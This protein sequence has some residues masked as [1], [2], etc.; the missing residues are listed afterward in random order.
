[1]PNGSSAVVQKLWNY[2]NTPSG[3]A[4]P[5]CALGCH[6]ERSRQCLMAPFRTNQHFTLKTN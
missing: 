3:T 2:C 4:I 6:A 1:M 5:G